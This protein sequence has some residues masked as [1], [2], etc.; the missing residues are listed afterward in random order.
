MQPLGA[1][2]QG[3]RRG[4]NQRQRAR[5][6]S[7]ERHL[8]PRRF[9]QAGRRRLCWKSSDKPGLHIANPSGKR[10]RAEQRA[11]GVSQLQ[12][13]STPGC[14]KRQPRRTDTWRIVCRLV[15]TI[16]GCAGWLCLIAILAGVFSVAAPTAR[17]QLGF[18]VPSQVYYSAFS[19]YWDGDY[20]E[21]LNLF[22]GEARGGIKAGTN[23]WIDSICYFTM[24]GEC[25]Y[26][27]GQHQ[28]GADAVHQ[29]PEAFTM[30]S[31][32]GWCGSSFRRAEF[33]RRTP[34]SSD[35]CLGD[36]A[37]AFVL[38]HYHDTYADHAGAIHE[39][40][41]PR[42]PRGGRRVG[43]HGLLD[44][45]ARNRALHGAGHAAAA[46]D[47]WARPAQDQL[48]NDLVTVL[49]RRPGPANHWSGM[50]DRP[51]TGHRL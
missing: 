15:G 20:R 29:R 17:C 4:A 10:A 27:M 50:L 25:Y 21:A 35:L 22:Q 47:R 6:C 30:P 51:A 5:N 26:Q 12:P 7:F 43:P 45:R 48:T 9:C 8:R 37:R 38:G 28:A 40:A 23:R 1:P 31:T 39:P 24:V 42:Q 49:A 33:A 41:E 32:I 11:E 18:S 14:W 13:A 2:L 34:A 36:A 16:V 46:R 44:R 3:R 19:S